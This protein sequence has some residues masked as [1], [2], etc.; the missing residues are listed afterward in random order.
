MAHV[1]LCSVCHTCQSRRG[2]SLSLLAKGDCVCHVTRVTRRAPSGM[3][4]AAT[5]AGVVVL[6]ALLYKVGRTG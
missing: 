2:R 6:V 3:V 5:V 1:P 4:A